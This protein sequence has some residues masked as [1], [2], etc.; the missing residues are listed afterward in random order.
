MLG[1]TRGG[2]KSVLSPRRDSNFPK[3]VRFIVGRGRTPKLK[4]ALAA[5]AGS[6]VSN[7]SDG[8]FPT[9]PNA[10][11]KNTVAEILKGQKEDDFTKAYIIDDYIKK[12]FTVIENN[13]AQLSN[14]DYI[15]KNKSASDLGI[16]KIYGHFLT[17]AN[18]VYLPMIT[19]NVYQQKPI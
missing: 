18:V 10:D 11:I 2:G 7:I 15:L 14:V 19:A 12:N 3:R 9:T 16:I 1:P 17:A 8:M 5:A 13:N 4:L 6:A